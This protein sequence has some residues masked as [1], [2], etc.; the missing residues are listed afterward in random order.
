MLH[1]LD[2]NNF[3]K[4][5]VPVTTSDYFTIGEEFHPNGIF[6][7]EIFGNKNTR[8]RNKTFSYIELGCE[9][10]HPA[11]L[12]ILLRLDKK[13]VQSIIEASISYSLDSEGNLIEDEN[14]FTGITSFIK[15]YS[16]IKWRGDSSDREKF[17]AKL[18]ESYEKKVLFI[19]KIPVIPPAY[20]PI[21]KDEVSGRWN[22]DPLN[23][24]LIN[25]IKRVSLIKTTPRE[26]QGLIDLLIYELQKSIIKL[27]DY[28]QTL[29][30]KKYG[31]IREQLLG[32]RCDFSGR[33]VITP[34]VDMKINQI[35]IPFKICTGLF[36]P[37]IIYYILKQ[38][39][40]DKLQILS[41]DLV[42]FINID[43]SPESIRSILKSIQY[44]HKIPESIY[45]LFYDVTKIVMEGRVVLAKRDPALHAESVRGFHAIL[46]EGETIQLC[47]AQVGGFNADF[48]G[49][50]MAIFHPL[51]LESQ[52]E[53]KDKFLRLTTGDS[54]TSVAFDLSKEI[55]LGLYFITKP[56][57]N[58]SNP[59]N[60]TTDELD[61]INDP[62]IAVKHRG[63]ITSSGKAIFNS[64]FPID[65]PFISEQIT[66]KEIKKL[67]TQ[68]IKK[69]KE[70]TV[71]EIFFKLQ[72]IGFKFVTIAGSSFLLDD[73]ILPP[74]II[75]LKNKIS[76]SSPE[77]AD[78]LLKQAEKELAIHLKNTGFSDIIESDAAKGWGQ[79]KQI[80]VAKG[81]ISDPTGKILDPI[82][83]SFSD[84]LTPIEYFA[85]AAGA[86]KGIMD[87]VLNTSIT[88][89]QARKL[90]FI[91]SNVELHHSLDNCG[92]TRTLDLK[93]DKK[94]SSQLT[95]RYILPSSKRKPVLFNSDNY[96]SGDII[97]LRTPIYCRSP[98][99]CHTCYGNLFR[100]HMSPYIGI[101]AAQI[102]GEVGT[103]FTMKTFHTGGAV[104]IKKRDL[105]EEIISNDLHLTPEKLKEILVQN[106]TK[107]LTSPKVDS[108]YLTIDL[109]NYEHRD[110]EIRDDEI[111]VKSLVSEIEL[112]D[113]QKYNVII[114]S[115][116]TLHFQTKPIKENNKIRIQY[117]PN[118][119]ILEVSLESNQISELARYVERLISGR[120]IYKNVDHLF[121]KLYQVY[122]EMSDMDIVHLEVLLSQCL[123]DKTTPGLT[124]RLGKEWNPIMMNIRKVVFS[125][126]FFSGLAF[127]NI[128]AAIK[129]GLI[130]EDIN[131]PSIIERTLTGSLV[132]K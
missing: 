100:R 17:I 89:Y 108:L 92:T 35:G 64:C 128:G 43:I 42:K 76:G 84:G 12:S 81:V 75:K 7:E 121:K 104:D 73:L 40:K 27:D 70:D 80:L 74:N 10:I 55:L 116:V 54:S 86:R 123:R 88:G 59:I 37:F 62:T 41:D 66:K 53:I 51:S 65:F 61:K 79:A 127:E 25:V 90:A 119:I 83:S 28:L 13:K 2:M 131:E 118:S 96:K 132:T 38:L 16:K 3:S 98:K 57:I 20:R 120:E 68:V 111:W 45:S 110:Y 23:A 112:S 115:A 107:L 125:S 93:L 72:K 71:I 9:I 30:Q 97:L 44:G 63:M 129:S 29:V 113:K 60:V 47:A 50:Q 95:G 6:S 87:R 124:A 52:A 24:Y 102:I 103:Q 106:E 19:D 31:L 58:K 4:K 122:S 109:D 99:V 130:T 69:Y 48:D 5:L 26:G 56:V 101:V 18:N 36:E 78:K 1:F 21:Y 91:L 34:S 117:I 67:T 46:V 94:L 49:D 85:A 14:G 82:G 114:D 39:P 33:A 22:D 11:A 8:E 126:S 32:A 105:L 77:V 15:N